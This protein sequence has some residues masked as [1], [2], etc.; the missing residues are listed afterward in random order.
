MSRRRKSVKRKVTP[1]SKYDSLL[2][3]K[4]INFVMEQGKKTIAESIVY[5]AFDL[6]KEKGK[7]ENPLEAFTSAVKS[8]E[9]KIEVKSRRV[10][11][12]TYQVPVDVEENR[13]NVL[14]I[15][16]ILASVKK[17]KE[18]TASQRLFSEV[19]DIL[20]GRGN[21]LKTRE[22]THKMAEANRAFAHYKW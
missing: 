5:D 2:V 6:I 7:Q 15:R 20:A 3:A 22:N 18:R 11:G 4:F 10:G 13:A 8:V 14:A 19:M 17:R 16:W 9:P 12:A 21:S 1:D